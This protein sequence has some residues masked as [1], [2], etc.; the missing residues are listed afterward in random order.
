[1]LGIKK[2]RK[3]MGL[4]GTGW[5]IGEKTIPVISPFNL[6]PRARWTFQL[7]RV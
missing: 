7:K 2:W 6:H 4:A 1:M 5:E 3:N